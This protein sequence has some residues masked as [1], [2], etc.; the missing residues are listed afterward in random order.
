MSESEDSG[1]GIFRI[2][3]SP[4]GAKP[5]V[6]I[7]GTFTNPPWQQL[8]MQSIEL[9]NSGEYRHEIRLDIFKGQ[10]Y[11]YKFRLGKGDWWDLNEEEPIV[12]DAAGNHNNL[13]PTKVNDDGWEEKELHDQDGEVWE[14]RKLTKYAAEERK[15]SH[16]ASPLETTHTH[17]LKTAQIFPPLTSA[18]TQKTGKPAVIIP[19]PAIDIETPL[20]TEESHVEHLTEKNEFDINSQ[21][22][23]EDPDKRIPKPN[24]T[25][26]SNRLDAKSS[27]EISTQQASNINIAN[28]AAEVADIAATLDREP[29]SPT[30]SGVESSSNSLKRLSVALTS[31]AVVVPPE[32]ANITTAQNDEMTT[33]KTIRQIID[34]EAEKLFGSGYTTPIEDQV[35]RFSHECPLS[36]EIVESKRISSRNVS[37]SKPTRQE[38]VPENIDFNDPSIQLFPTDRASIM[39]KLKEIQERLPEDEAH[40]EGVPQSPIVPPEHWTDFKQPESVSTNIHSNQ[41]PT[42]LQPIT[43]EDN[44]KSE[45]SQADES[46]KTDNSSTN[47]QL[48]LVPA[49]RKHLTNES[50]T[51]SEDQNTEDC[52]A[53]DTKQSISQPKSSDEK[54][55]ETHPKS[56]NLEQSICEPVSSTPQMIKSHFISHNDDQEGS[57]KK[58]GEPSNSE[59]S[60]GPADVETV[61]VE[62]NP[63]LLTNGKQ[64]EATSTQVASK[65]TPQPIQ[66]NLNCHQN[67]ESRDRSTTCETRSKDIQGKSFLDIIWRF[68]KLDWISG[69]IKRFWSG[70]KRNI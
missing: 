13:L 45:S 24:A 28:T 25:D 32:V 38:D 16:R 18:S 9:E 31:K 34:E 20:E 48:V 6:F 62:S 52:R 42:S 58:P 43:E 54:K 14:E 15:K 5:P 59:I 55:E 39:A 11:Q 61:V 67:L 60:S 63:T 46:D 8:E 51:V 41:L 69:F 35:P 68:F 50:N 37:K 22:T 70:R 12:V 27:Y 17:E 1:R 53:D 3:F 56:N 23:K 65:N 4:K 44:G 2:S 7:A 64:Y 10:D 57:K 30:S 21:K 26:E 40:F 29:L 49:E 19:S 66:R 47:D 33:E 36:P